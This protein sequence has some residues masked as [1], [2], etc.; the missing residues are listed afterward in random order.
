MSLD[1]Y[2]ILQLKGDNLKKNGYFFQ[3]NGIL[4]IQIIVIVIIIDNKKSKNLNIKY[5]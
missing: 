3:I 2:I 4:V 1:I 5:K